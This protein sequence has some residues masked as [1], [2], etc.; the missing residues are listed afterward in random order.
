MFINLSS[1]FLIFSTPSGEPDEVVTRPLGHMERTPLA[2]QQAV[3]CPAQS[4]IQVVVLLGVNC[5]TVHLVYDCVSFF[6]G[7]EDFFSCHGVYPLSF[8]LELS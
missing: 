4:L 5:E 2:G 6:D 7:G 8:S 1:T 3:Q